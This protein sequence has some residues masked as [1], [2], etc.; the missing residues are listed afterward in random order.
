VQ[1]AFEVV[2]GLGLWRE[3]PNANPIPAASPRES[4]IATVAAA[5]K[6]PPEGLVAYGAVAMPGNRVQLPCYGP[7]GLK[8]STLTFG[9]NDKGLLA[10][11][12]P[13]G[14]FFP[15]NEGGVILPKPG[16]TWILV[17]GPK[18]SAAL[19]CSG[20]KTCGL[21][22]AHLNAKF[23]SLFTGVNCVVVPDHD[24]PGTKGAQSTAAALVGVAASV[25]IAEWPANLADGADVRDVL[26]LEGGCEIVARAIA[27][28][29]AALNAQREQQIVCLERITTKELLENSP[30]PVWLIKQ[31]FVEQQPGGILGTFKALKTSIAADAKISLATGTPFMGH[32]EVPSARRVGGISG[33]SG[34]HS[35]SLLAK[36]ICAARGIDPY[37]ELDNLIWSTEIPNLTK[38]I[39]L[40]RLRKFIKDD[41]LEVCFFD[42]MYLLLAG[43]AKDASNMFAMG[44]VLANLSQVGKDTG[45]SLI[46]VHHTSRG[47]S[48]LRGYDPPELGDSA[49]SGTAEYLRQWMCLGRR[50]QY[51]P[52]SGH[53]ELWL[54]I[55]G[56]AGQSGLYAVD[57]D[58]GHLGEDF[59]G[60]VW[61]VAVMRPDEAREGQKTAAEQAKATR[62]EE[63][64]ASDKSIVLR[65][66]ARFPNGETKN[67]AADGAGISK[68]RFSVAV[69]EL[70]NEGELEQIKIKKGKRAED[71][72]ILA[73]SELVGLGRTSYPDK[74]ESGQTTKYPDK[75]P[76]RGCPGPT[77]SSPTSDSLIEN[78]KLSGQTEGNE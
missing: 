78:E 2:Q 41:A 46:M 17:E 23:A 67:T 37:T 30:K 56:S 31:V 13:A 59:E 32:F 45:C 39:D 19:F 48:R 4:I 65:A 60:R 49:F 58:E 14:L 1:R 16:E 54:S 24:E 71:G 52:D 38:G 44:D 36:R 18:D 10:K 8:C 68:G 72:F 22:T 61:N 66:F 21:N 73:S 20:Y 5:K 69:A 27:E 64:L 35:L 42:P 34:P 51:A 26:Q 11:D 57:V 12:H 40:E 3:S 28:A 43:A 25:R 74:V 75:Q 77:R 53:H 62:Q 55:G 47:A 15:H 50:S 76:Y 33:E 6:V 70:V 9:T 29:K 7:D 63:Q